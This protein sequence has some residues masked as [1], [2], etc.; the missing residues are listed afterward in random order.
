MQTQVL[1]KFLLMAAVSDVPDVTR[2]KMAVRGILC[3][4]EQ[5]FHL[6]KLCG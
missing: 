3:L 6:K 2:Q 4:L 1:E 5:L